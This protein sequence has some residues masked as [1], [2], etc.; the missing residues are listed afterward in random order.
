ME[1]VRRTCHKEKYNSL[2]NSLIFNLTRWTHTFSEKKHQK[3]YFFTTKHHDSPLVSSDT[4]CWVPSFIWFHTYDLC[5]RSRERNIICLEREKVIWLE[6]ERSREEN[7]RDFLFHVNQHLSNE[8][9][10][11]YIVIHDLNIRKCAVF[12]YFTHS[13]LT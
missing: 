13:T 11:A 5:L 7:K 8:R 4:N 12:T 2:A 10:Q 9:L 6:R 3:S 1:G